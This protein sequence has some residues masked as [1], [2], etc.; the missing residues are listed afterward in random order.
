ML[1][2]P[3]VIRIYVALGPVDLHESFNGL[4]ATVAEQ[5][6]E[7]RTIELDLVPGRL[8]KSEIVRPKYR[9]RLDRGRSPLLAPAPARMIPGWV[10][11]YEIPVAASS[12]R[13][14]AS[15]VAGWA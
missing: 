8:V 3:A 9:H 15:R 10:S 5:L 2:F 7:E 11:R 1:A 12:A 14:T 4:W 6:R 13:H